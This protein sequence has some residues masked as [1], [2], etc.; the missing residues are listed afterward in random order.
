MELVASTENAELP[1]TVPARLGGKV[2][3]VT[4][5]FHCLDVITVPV[6]KH[7]NATAM[8]DGREP[9]VTF[10]VAIIALMETA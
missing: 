5:V 4:S 10:P 1:I 6:E 9:I 2:P 3:T 7:L 8:K